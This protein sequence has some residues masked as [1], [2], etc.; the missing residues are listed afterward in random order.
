MLNLRF[1]LR[2]TQCAGIELLA[3]GVGGRKVIAI[4]KM[5]FSG[6]VLGIQKAQQRR[7]L[8]QKLYGQ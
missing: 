1:S 4:P 3:L 6:E 2:Q 5:D 8:K 7:E